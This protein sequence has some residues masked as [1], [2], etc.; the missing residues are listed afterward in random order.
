MCVFWN[1]LLAEINWY[2]ILVNR[3]NAASVIFFC[4]FDVHRVCVLIVNV[5]IDWNDRLG[6]FAAWTIVI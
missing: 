3:F 2:L 5:I 6:Y 1:M 4:I